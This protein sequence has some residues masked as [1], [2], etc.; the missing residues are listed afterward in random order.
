MSTEQK[1]HYATK[2][3][4]GLHT[5]VDGTTEGGACLTGHHA[6]FK[7]FRGKCTCNYRY[8]AYEHSNS[9]GAIKSKLHGYNKKSLT[10][11]ISTSA[12]MGKSGRFPSH[13]CATL[14]PP[15]PG[16][17]NIGGPPS[18]ITRRRFG[19][20]VRYVTIPATKN[21]TQDTWPYWN[22]AHHIIPKGT[23]KDRITQ[24]KDKGVSD[25]IQQCLLE[26][27]YNINY[28][29]NMV[30]LPQDMEVANILGVP[31]HLQL[32]HADG[33]VRVAVG[34]HPVYNEMVLKAKTGL[35]KIVAEYAKIC[36]DAITKANKTKHKI[37]K[38]QLSK[39]KLEKLSRDL[40]AWI[41]TPTKAG[42]SLDA[43][44]NKGGF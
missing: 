10:A 24:E 9:N 29:I 42:I 35:E 17:W 25:L 22:N 16:D 34:N 2:K 36:K 23:L 32:Q 37:P 38:A 1:G 28:K 20:G 31:R 43:R 15:G 6:S 7:D 44:A 21:F 30:L 19:K 39:K 3:L 27:K 11:A 41:L 18:D 14:Q 40:L 4:K 26:A 5:K 33:G 12:P 8:Q 13:Y